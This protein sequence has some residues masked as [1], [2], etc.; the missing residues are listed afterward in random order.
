MKE[1]RGQ[2]CESLRSNLLSARMTRARLLTVATAGAAL[3]AMPTAARAQDGSAASM[4]FPFFPRVQGTYTPESISDILNTLITLHYLG[5]S[6]TSLFLSAPSTFGLSGIGLT[7]TQAAVAEEQYRLDFLASLGAVPV[8]TSFTAPAALLSSPQA[9]LAILEV[10]PTIGMAAYMTAVR[11][12]A[13]LGQ[14][15]LAKWAYQAGAQEAE[16]RA[17]FRFLAVLAKGSTAVPN[18]K[19]FESDLFLYVSE[20]LDTLRTLGL[21]G[22]SGISVTYPGR[23]AVLAAAGPMAAAVLQQTPNNATSPLVITGLPSITGERS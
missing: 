10:P 8:T 13:E 21:I 4:S 14:P 7:I 18:N 5:T 12:F 11:E 2:S 15:E 1:S 9:A 20:A 19:A 22:G 16:L 6:G 23:A 3:A 17:T